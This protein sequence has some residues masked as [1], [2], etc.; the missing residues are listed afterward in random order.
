MF[1]AA[2]MM[3]TPTIIDKLILPSHYSDHSLKYIF[4]L[5]YD[6]INSFPSLL[7]SLIFKPTL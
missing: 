2:L 7:F 1:A 4:I 6:L 3:I 5:L